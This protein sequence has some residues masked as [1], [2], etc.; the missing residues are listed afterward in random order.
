MSN[1]LNRLGSVLDKTQRTIA[2]VVTVNPN[3]T[4]L[5]QYSDGS[6]SVVLG[7]NVQEGA[8]YVENGRVVG[9]APTLPYTEIEI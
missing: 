7:D 5:V 8:V 4:T 6:H 2:T 9:A 1:T 3:G